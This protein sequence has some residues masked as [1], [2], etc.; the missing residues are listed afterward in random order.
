MGGGKAS[1]KDES[2]LEGGV[3]GDGIV[4]EEGIRGEVIF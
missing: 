1:V 2:R 3:R 4:G